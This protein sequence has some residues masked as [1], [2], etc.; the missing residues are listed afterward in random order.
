[1]FE[2]AFNYNGNTTIIQCNKEEK[3]KQ[4]FNKFKQKSGLDINSLYF[5][6]SGNKI[7]NDELNFEMIANNEDKLRRRMNIIVNDKNSFG[8]NSSIIKS[9]F[10]ICP[11]CD[12]NIKLIINDYKIFLYECKNNHEIDNISLNK[13]EETQKIDISKIKCDACKE[14]NKSESYNNIFYRCNSCKI[15]LCPICRNNHDK[16][17]YIID[18]DQKNY[19]CEK[20]N[21]IP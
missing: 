8:S 14:K 21:Q 16:T 13:F 15:N 18:Y 10:I 9:N 12:E 5:V 1:M 17:H 4:I 11:K 20:H 3:M 6:Y 2:I 19:I 7:T